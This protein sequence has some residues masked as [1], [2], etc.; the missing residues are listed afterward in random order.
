[1]RTS[2]SIGYLVKNEYNFFLYSL[3]SPFSAILKL[4]IR[5][6]KV[7][8]QIIIAEG[9]L[10]VAICPFIGSFLSFDKHIN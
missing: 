1:M 6:F 7:F 9:S 4:S 5:D 3:Y 8:P 10:F 2:T